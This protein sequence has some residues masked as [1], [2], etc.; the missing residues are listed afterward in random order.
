[1]ARGKI[2]RTRAHASSVET[3]LSTDFADFARSDF[4]R[5][6]LSKSRCPVLVASEM[7]GFK[8]VPSPF[9]WVG[10]W[11]AGEGGHLADRRTQ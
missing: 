6:V 8:V 5:S 9:G 7:S 11:V 4:A 1:M 2:V 10:D 3:A